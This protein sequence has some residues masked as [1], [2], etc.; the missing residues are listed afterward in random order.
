MPFAVARSEPS[1][2]QERPN[3]RRVALPS[4]I[5]D[6]D[7]HIDETECQHWPCSNIYTR[8]DHFWNCPKGE[9]EINC[10]KSFC[11]RETLACVLPN[12]NGISGKPLKYKGIVGNV[13]ISD[14]MI[15][16]NDN[17]LREHQKGLVREYFQ[18]FTEEG[19]SKFDWKIKQTKG[20]LKVRVSKSIDPR[21]LKPF[22]RN[23]KL[24]NDGL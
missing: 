14:Q 3:Y 20:I 7:N 12:D 1:F 22:R 18:V 9:D 11:S 4:M 13:W 17:N 6:E 23:T 24:P 10:T 15:T 2:V 5:I 21:F 8:C 19:S 16:N